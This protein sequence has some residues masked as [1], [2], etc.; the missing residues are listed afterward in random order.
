VIKGTKISPIVGS[1][2]NS[3]RGPTG[4]LNSD[5]AASAA[6]R[7]RFVMEVVMRRTFQGLLAFAFSLFGP[8]LVGEEPRAAEPSVRDLVKQ[9]ED[10]DAEKAGAAARALGKLRPGKEAVRGLK[11]L[12]TRRNGRLRWAA[13]EALWKLEHKATDLVPVYAELLTA[14]D[15]DVRAAS[16]WRL[17][18]LGG[19]ARPA[20]AVLAAALRDEDFEVRVQVGQALANLGADAGLALPALVRALGDE[21]LDEPRSG[22]QGWESARNSPALPA[23]VALADESIPLLIETFRR[24]D[25]WTQGGDGPTPRGWEVASRAAFAFPAFGGR[26]V[27]PLLQALRAKDVETREYAAVALR[28]A[29]QFSGLPEDAVDQL[30]KSLDD[31]D[32]HVRSAAAG[33][34]SWVRPSCAKAVAIL[35]DARKDLAVS[36]SDLLEALGRMGPHNEGALKLLFRMLGDDDAET[37]RAAHITLARLELPPEQVLGAWTRALSHPDPK[38]RLEADYAL[39]SLGPAAKPARSALHERLTRE[40]DHDVKVGSI[41]ALTAIDPDDPELMTFLTRAMEDGDSSI[42]LLDA[43]RGLNDLG[44]RAKDAIPKIEA[45]LFKPRGEGRDDFWDGLELRDLATALTRIAPG[46]AESAAT[47]LRALRRPGIRHRHCPKNT[48]YMRDVLEDQLLSHLPAAEPALRGALKDEDAEVRRSAALVLVRAGRDV[49]TALPVLMEKLWDGSD[50]SGEQSRFRSRVV[51]VL[52]RRQTSASPAVAAAWCEAWQAGDPKAREILEPGLLVLQP[53]AL[54]HLLDQ[55]RR[56][57]TTQSRRDLAHLLAQF[58]GQA[59]L[60]LPIL[61]EE[62]GERRP[63]AQYEAAR[64]LTLLGPEAAEAVP[65]LARLLG[66]PNPGM[67]A[68]AARAL[69]GIGRASRPAVPALKAMLKEDPPLLRLVAADALSRI[70]ADVSEALALLRDVLAVQKTEP[71]LRFA[72]SIELPEGVKD[73]RVYPDI[74][75]AEGIARF[76]ERAAPMLA[77]LLDDV[78]LDEWSAD[79]VS[80]QCGSEA[81]VQAA[82][83]LARLGPEAKAAVPALVRALKDRDPF[84]REAAASALGRVGPAAKDAAPDLIRLLEQQNRS[85]SVEGAWSSSPRAGSPSGP[86]GPYGYGDPFDFRSAGRGGALSR[87]MGF[88][89]YGAR[90]PYA[91]LRPAHPYDAAYVLGRID[92]ESRSALPILSAAAKDPKHPGRLSAALAMWR[93]GCEAPDL[94]PAFAA[95]LE[96]HAKLPKGDRAALSREVRECLAELD[97]QLKPAARVMAEWLKRRQSSAEEGD[98]VAIVEALGRLGKDARSEADLLR[99]LLRADDWS[100]RRDVAVALALFRIRGEKD[101]AFPVLREALLGLE[102]HS[103]IY[104]RADP[105][106][107]ARVHAARA[108]GVLAEN[109]DERA[110]ALIVEAAKGD[111]NPHV[112]LA[113]LEALAR[114]KQTNAAAVRGLCATL[115]HQDA[116]VRTE[117]A[118]ACGRLGPR[119]KSALKALQAAAGDGQLAVRQAARWALDQLE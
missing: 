4:A 28:E 23:L 103:S 48:W 118:S 68:I 63:D 96:A 56:A 62:L 43:I 15:A 2:A 54:P 72:E 47:L 36:R 3:P 100:A 6:F 92:G 18:R 7:H 111:E 60:V 35:A 22:R 79:N 61:R 44:P 16:A 59:T 90:D 57:K 116:A 21:R 52:M 74:S 55:F 5:S 82:L 76:G 104:H 115:R 77:D 107:T 94:V 117:A 75:V 30:E 24:N 39:M 37:A 13:A 67:R 25:S 85:A 86:T 50:R 33:A 53:E 66:D 41:H 105:A 27:G 29:A 119:A 110:Q 98:Q 12:L 49:E 1:G 46:S 17:G 69:G 71:G 113:A 32:K 51:E 58:E 89:Y 40:A 109:G 26:A 64:A 108:L 87:H 114:Q 84:I 78:D 14:A 10:K 19:D 88:G 70:D 45:R 97:A 83:L 65:E 81:R 112:R 38:V 11:E 99:P 31:P 80:A 20:A 73:L 42:R 93:T 106:D 101:L 95:A 9:L 8:S 102:E 34:M 91:H